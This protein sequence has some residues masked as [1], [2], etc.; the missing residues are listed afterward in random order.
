MPRPNMLALASIR[1]VTRHSL[2][3]DLAAQA[4]AEAGN[5]KGGQLAHP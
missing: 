5:T 2:F 1:A 3:R 4:V